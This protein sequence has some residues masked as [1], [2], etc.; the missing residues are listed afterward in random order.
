MS[1]VSSGTGYNQGIV[2]E[3]IGKVKNAYEELINAI[4]NQMQNDFV[5]GLSDKWACPDAQN[6]FNTSFKPTVDQLIKGSNNTFDTVVR[7][8]NSAGS[9]WAATV[10]GT[11]DTVTFSTINK[12]METSS[13]L[14]NI[15][16]IQGIDEVDTPTVLNQLPVIAENAKVA[17]GNAVS[18]VQTSG[19]LDYAN[20]QAE[21][22][23]NSLNQ[24]KNNIDS[25]VQTITTDSDRAIK[26][27]IERYGDTK[28]RIAAAFAGN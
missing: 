2:H 25:A 11:Y 23:I 8:M 3:S 15:N 19:F 9:A 13:I 5:G 12:E 7:S 21:N 20:I 27:T 18:A 4:G 16:G 6:F 26:N 24:I 17:L 14:E 22:L 28:G 1:L 10:G